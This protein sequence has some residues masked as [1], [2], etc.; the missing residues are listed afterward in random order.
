MSREQIDVALY[1]LLQGI[2]AFNTSSR[3][4][5]PNWT[6]TPAERQPA[7]FLS[8]G[9]ETL[10]QEMQKRGGPYVSTIEYTVIL[11]VHSGGQ[12]NSV[13]TS[14]LNP[15]VDSVVNAVHLTNGEKQTLGG[16]VHRLIIS[17]PIET[18]EGLLGDQAI[19]VF[20]LNVIATGAQ[21]AEP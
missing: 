18:D 1:S 6:E 2:T 4:V 19:A 17:G 3:R 20:T 13:P 15:M 5:P 9:K 16:L 21:L 12:V 8:H 11:M 10:D 14:R 7:L